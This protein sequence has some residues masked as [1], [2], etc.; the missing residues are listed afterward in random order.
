MQHR[1]FFLTRIILAAGVGLKPG[2]LRD[3]AFDIG[4][5]GFRLRHGDDFH[6]V[7]DHRGGPAADPHGRG[8]G[9]GRGARFHGATEQHADAAG[10][11]DV[12]RGE[13]GLLAVG[14]LVSHADRSCRGRS[15]R[16]ADRRRMRPTRS[17]RRRSRVFMRPIIPSW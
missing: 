16:L 11:R 8:G 2:G 5:R 17:F 15:R 13:R 9:D 12:R 7:G 1:F 14:R 3:F 4:G 10:E 6:G